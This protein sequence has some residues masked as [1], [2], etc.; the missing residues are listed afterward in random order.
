MSRKLTKNILIIFILVL[1]PVLTSCG[2]KDDSTQ[3]VLISEKDKSRDLETP[4]KKDQEKIDNSDT[5]EDKEVQG[6]QFVQQDHFY[7]DTVLIEIESDKPCDIYY[8]TDGTDP[9]ES[10][11]LY[12]EHIKLASRT[13]TK[14]YSI[15]AI[16]YYEDG[17]Q[18][19]I[20]T[21]T[22]FVGKNIDSRFDT[23]VFS[24]TT[25]P[26]N[27]YDYEY[28]IFIPGKLRDDYIRENPHEHIE[29]PAPA[30][31]NMR[32]RESE[33][34]VYL[35]IFEPDGSRIANQD[36]GIRVYG[37]WSRA[38]SQ[39]SIKIFARKAYD[40]ENNKIRY[41]FFPDEK[42]NKE[43]GTIVDRFKRLV[44]RN[45]GNDHDHGFIRDEMVQTLAGQAGYKDY[46]SVRPVA[47]FI[48]GEYHG[49]YWLH[50][51]YCNEYF[52]E[53][54]G[55][56]TGT[57]EVLEGG[58]NYKKVDE[59]GS[60]QYAIDDY[61]EAY[62]YTY[63]DL[64]NDTVY[65]KLSEVI[66]VENYLAYYAL[67]IYIGN[68]DWPHNNY[69]V[70]RYYPAEG[71]EYREAPF[72]GKWRYLFHDLDF[73]FAIYGTGPW[74]D[75]FRKFASKSGDIKRESPL[76]SQL[77]RRE[78]CREF[79]VNKSLDLINGAF[80]KDNLNRVLDEMNQARLNE[81]SYMYGTNLVADWVHPNQLPGRMEDI[82]DYNSSRITYTLGKYR[83][84]FELGK[85]FK[86]NVYPAG[87]GGVRI[88]GIETY[89]SFEG[90][91]YP[92]YDIV[93]NPIIPA[94]KELDYWV[95]N[96]DAYY[97]WE[98]IINSSM[99]IEDE[100]DVVCVFKEKA[101][102]PKLLISEL[103]SYGDQDYIIL[104]NPYEEDIMMTGYSI[105]DDVNEPGKLILPARALKSGESLKILGES[106]RET[107]TSDMIRAGYNL[108]DGETVTLYL[109]GE[110]IDEVTIPD[111]GKGNIYK[112]DMKTLRFFE[113]K[114]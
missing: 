74:V 52:E 34:E 60:N 42:I 20:I 24:V 101:E 4:D 94:G 66:D 8:T 5:S 110:I 15:K 111:L 29:P 85:P 9:D 16:G 73:S 32:G 17:S 82:K 1:I 44:L 99:I 104:T 88:N 107:P 43:N 33:R 100:V 80:S 35:E 83:D 112:R 114:R 41:E 91:Y 69:K 108:K 19:D 2:K 14:V 3:E 109:E 27:L 79:F 47:L 102:N 57:F 28:G 75:N 71:E 51:V 54:Y 67:Q 62:S 37:G 77:L 63:D 93:I 59:D 31:Y 61:E 72:D 76:F 39:K 12:Q 38:N 49:F 68:E 84:F 48:N 53:H 7:K 25:D 97:D 6:L 58:E 95:V 64:T 65:E 87:G 23:L 40:E 113:G 18:T 26:Y 45:C 106:N 92:D 55:K 13:T 11:K 56:F 21:H 36:A 70:Y 30:N 78:D 105:T 86:L 103:S 50:E 81:L 98:L 90:S 46:Q 10:K 89:K 96:K 22:Y